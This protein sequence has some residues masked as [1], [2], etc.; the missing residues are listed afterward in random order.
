MTET[1]DNEGMAQPAEHVEA[2]AE[3]AHE[4]S[5]GFVDKAK[6]VATEAW[7]KTKEMAGVVAERTKEVASHTA[8]A[9]KGKRVVWM[10]DRAAAKR[11]LHH[12]IQPRD[13]LLTLGA[14]DVNVLGQELVAGT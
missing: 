3:T 14:G 5:A 10:P 11:F 9:A 6:D 4:S 13:L 2:G 12:E 7:D 8:D 1:R